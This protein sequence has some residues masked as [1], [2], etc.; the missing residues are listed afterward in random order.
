MKIRPNWKWYV[1]TAFFFYCSIQSNSVGPILGWFLFFFV[2]VPV[3]YYINTHIDKENKKHYWEEVKNCII[4]LFPNKA[5][6]ALKDMEVF[7]NKVEKFSY[8]ESQKFYSKDPLSVACDIV[9]N[10]SGNL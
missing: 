1:V 4:R 8:K 9:K 7:K 10:D 6:Q 5:S 3:C 2:L